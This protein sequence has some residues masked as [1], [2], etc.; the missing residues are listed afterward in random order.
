MYKFE[1]RFISCM[2][3]QINFKNMSGCDLPENFIILLN[4]ATSCLETSMAQFIKMEAAL[5]KLK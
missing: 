5:Y 2:L 1:S 4:H 3:E